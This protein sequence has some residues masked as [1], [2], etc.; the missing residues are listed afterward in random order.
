MRPDLA[1]RVD[2]AVQQVATPVVVI[3]LPPGGVRQHIKSL[4]H[5]T[6]ARRRI[7]GRVAVGV[8]LRGFLA[9][10]LFDVSQRGGAVEAKGGVVVGQAGQEVIEKFKSEIAAS[11]MGMA[12]VVKL[13]KT[14]CG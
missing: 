11:A 4:L 1:R 3:S 7:A 10:S 8:I 5:R 14:H 9:K 13:Q 12:L 6:K 2:R